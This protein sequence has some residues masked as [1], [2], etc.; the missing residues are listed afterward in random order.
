[1]YLN[2][3]THH[4]EAD[5]AIFQVQNLVIDSAI[6]VE[7][8]EKQ[9]VNSLPNQYFSAG[10]HPWYLKETQLEADLALLKRI[11]THPKVLFLG[12]C[13]LDKICQTDWTFQI[14]VFKT[15][16]Q[17]AE[18]LQKPTVIHCVRAF[19]E[20]IQIKK[21][22]RPKFPWLIHGFNNNE[23]ILKQLIQHQLYV[24]LGA[25]L[26]QDKSNASRLI[27]SI[28]IKQ[29]FLETD[30]KNCTISSIF[31]AASNLLEV[32][33]EYLQEKIYANFKQIVEHQGSQ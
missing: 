16:I 25:A 3:H 30:D 8:W 4:I 9:L 24:S 2:I 29:L 21:L 31:V 19:S 28:P 11:L 13:G 10:L 23:Q 1:M 14:N 26:L 20:I 12:E 27:T 18:A 32:D 33:I 22:L 5:E 15:Q 17:I 7:V 6:P